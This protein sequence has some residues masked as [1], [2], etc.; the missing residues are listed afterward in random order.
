MERDVAEQYLQ[1]TPECLKPHPLEDYIFPPEK[2]P[3]EKLAY[4]CLNL[5]KLLEVY[6]DNLCTMAQT[7]NK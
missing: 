5:L 4:Q 1:K 7:T 3:D 2:C 6:V